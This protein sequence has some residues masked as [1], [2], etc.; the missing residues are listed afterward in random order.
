MVSHTTQ[1]KHESLLKYIW[2][3]SCELQES[4]PSQPEV[5][6]FPRTPIPSTTNETN[7]IFAI[8]CGECVH[9]LRI[10]QY[11]PSLIYS[12]SHNVKSKVFLIIIL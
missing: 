10:K 9:N 3:V 4:L 12:V 6:E 11:E 5:D 7:N 8:S 1:K 2:S